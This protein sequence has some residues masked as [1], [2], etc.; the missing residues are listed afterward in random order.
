MKIYK[1]IYLLIMKIKIFKFIDLQ[2]KM[3]VKNINIKVLIIQNKKLIKVFLLL[4]IFTKLMKNMV[5]I[6]PFMDIEKII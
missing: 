2:E 4:I 3:I 5:R 1:N 6:Y